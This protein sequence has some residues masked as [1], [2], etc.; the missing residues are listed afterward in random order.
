MTAL[1]TPGNWDRAVGNDLITRD[2]TGALSLYAG[3][4]ASNFG[5]ALQIGF[6]W[7]I[8]TYIG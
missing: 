4:N 1:V 5:A 7:N 3:N 6:G 8:M 2:C